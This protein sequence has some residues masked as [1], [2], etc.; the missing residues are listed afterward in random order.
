M[1]KLF[2]LLLTI[3]LSSLASLAQEEF[4]VPAS[5]TSTWPYLFGDFSNA[6][7]LDNNGKVQHMT[8]NLNLLNEEMQYLNNGEIMQIYPPE[9]VQSITVN[10]MLFI[11]ANKWFLQVVAKGEPMLVKRFHGNMNDVVETTGA[12]GTQSTV[13]STHGMSSIDLGGINNMNYEY[14]KKG[15]ES[16]KNFSVETTYY[17]K[18]GN[19]LVPVSKK[20]SLKLFPEQKSKIK[21]YIKQQNIDFKKQ[22]DILK[23]TEFMNNL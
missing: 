16:G 17:F 21:N 7:I 6:K 11:F 15:K 13:S 2:F 20:Q 19:Q 8:V 10:H 1:K 22:S 14:L 3:C 12:Y 4:V 18:L 5:R 23:L 9:N